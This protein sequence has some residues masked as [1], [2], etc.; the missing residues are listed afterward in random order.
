MAIDLG[1]ANV[2]VYLADEGIVVREPC[3]VAVQ[4]VKGVREVGA[5]GEEAKRRIGRTPGNIKAIRPLHAGVIAY[6]E[7]T[8]VML[9]Y[10]V[11]KALGNR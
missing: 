8:E 2:L 3:V 9:K 11:R 6:C 10:F 1:T 7:V 4:T 5:V